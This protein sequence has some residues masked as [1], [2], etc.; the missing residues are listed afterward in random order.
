MTELALRSK[1][2][3]GYDAA[4]VEAHRPLF[5]IEPADLETTEVWCL[6]EDAHQIAMI[7]LWADG[8]V[9]HLAM[10]FVDPALIGQGLGRRSF[11]FACDRAKALGCSIMSI[12]SDP[13][14]A[15]FYEAMGAELVETLHSRIVPG[16]PLPRFEITLA[17]IG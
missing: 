1:A 8:P 17:R 2:H 12:K 10:L 9:C 3:W 16:E 5:T 14:A 4:T 7:Q 13:G 11:A 15:P 6:S